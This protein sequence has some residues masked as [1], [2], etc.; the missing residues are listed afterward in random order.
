M[1][2]LL[3][4]LLLASVSAF[5]QLHKAPADSEY[6]YM[7]GGTGFEE[8]RD[9]K[10]T[11]GKG[12]IT[13]GTT[14]SFGPGIASVYLIKAD[15]SGNHQWSKTFGGAEEDYGYA[16]EITHDSGYFISG[17]SN[18]FN[19][20]H[21]YNGYYLKTDK[22]GQLLWQKTLYDE[23]NW[24]FIYNSCALPD[25]GFILCGQ[26]YATTDG[27]ANAYL[28][29]LNKNGDTLWTKQFGGALDEN[30]KAVCV[31]NN[32]I[33]AV[34]SNQSAAADNIGDGWVAKIDMKGN[35]LGQKNIS[36]GSKHEE[37]IRGITPYTSSQFNFCGSDYIA[38]SSSTVAMISRMDTSLNYVF[39][40]SVA[41]EGD[42]GAGNEMI[43]N[44]IVNLS[45]GN[46]AMI[47]DAIRGGQQRNM[48]ILGYHG[49]GY[50]IDQYI[51]HCGGTQNDYGY[52][53]LRTA[54]GKLICV[55][56][57]AS[58]ADFCSANLGV[59][60]A[61][62]VRFNC[63]S[64]DYNSVNPGNNAHAAYHCFADTLAFWAAGIVKNKTPGSMLLYPN[65]ATAEVSI[66]G[67][68]GENFESIVIY[69]IAGEKV[70]NKT[71][72]SVS[73]KIDISF[74]PEGMYFLKAE[75]K[76]GNTFTAK[77]IISR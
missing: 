8:L 34:G 11:P 67:Y 49:G 25:S 71:G 1:K 36:L 19:T 39:S 65:P 32:R 44:K 68:I 4:I 28:V 15:S 51:D 63:D 56:S 54:S 43:F 20:S 73:Q 23:N 10:E 66:T 70:W 42:Y 61:F 38:D 7:Y 50:W 9:I 74:L 55:G 64:I 18:S 53:G 30:F 41:V 33:Y 45:Y 75:G 76:P 58:S 60:D 69:N 48:F 26:T 5:A 21:N 6:F 14:N 12:L 62:L 35:L 59:D 31:M 46:F 52:N 72:S 27:T 40:Y 77:F 3:F 17:Y 47:G 29:R 24:N 2:K 13:V 37:N 16:V 22:N 57:I